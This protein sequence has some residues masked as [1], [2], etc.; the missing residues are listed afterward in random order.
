MTPSEVLTQARQRF[1]VLLIQE[2]E[3]LVGFLRDAMEFYGQH[4]GVL[5]RRVAENPEVKIFP[6]PLAHNGCYNSQG[7]W[8]LTTYDQVSGIL[9]IHDQPRNSPW[10]LSYFVNPRK[11]D[12]DAELPPDCEFS[13]LIDLTECLIGEANSQRLSLSKWVAQLES[14]DTRNQAEYQ[15]QRVAVEEQI[16]K[17][18]MLPDFALL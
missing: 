12:L 6:P 13:L 10:N 9:H 15:Q 3:R 5:V 4:A 18:A 16:R 14:M 7:E 8:Q 1:E 17:Q 11:W 2:E